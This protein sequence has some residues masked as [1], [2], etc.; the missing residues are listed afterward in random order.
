[1]DSQDRVYLSNINESAV[2]R[3]ASGKMEKLASDPRLE[4]PDT[5]SQGPD[6]MIYVTA[7]HINDGPQ[8]NNGKSTRKKAYAVF[9]FRPD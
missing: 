6:G 2:Y 7:S 5:F 9:R 1:M 8:F 3:F 4:W